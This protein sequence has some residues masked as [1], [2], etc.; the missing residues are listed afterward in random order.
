MPPLSPGTAPRPVSAPIVGLPDP[1]VSAQMVERFL[2]LTP[3]PVL[4]PQHWGQVLT[5]HCV[6]LRDEGVDV[7]PF[8]PEI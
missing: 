2:K 4:L 5:P 6:T 7:F 1:A 8:H 3:G